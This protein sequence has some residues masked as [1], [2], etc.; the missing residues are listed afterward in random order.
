[1]CA[2][3][4]ALDSAFL[5]C[6]SVDV[7]IGDQ[8]SDDARDGATDQLAALLETY[9]GDHQGGVFQDLVGPVVD[10]AERDNLEPARK[11]HAANC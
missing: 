9:G 11:F 4:E 1:M 8:A 5:L 6:E 2:I 10:G 3:Q 7:L